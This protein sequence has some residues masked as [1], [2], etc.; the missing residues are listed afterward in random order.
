MKDF[1]LQT[2]EK[3]LNGYLSLDP[4]SVKRLL[5]LDKKIISLH[6][7]MTHFQIKI[8]SGRIY[9]QDAIEEPHVL[10]RGTPFSFLHAALLKENRKSFF[11]DHII[12][13]GD[14][15]LG[16]QIIDLF[17]ELEIDWEE[18]LSKVTGDVAAHQIGNVAR[19]THDFLKRAQQSFLKQTSEYVHEEA[20]LFP[21]R[22]ALEDFF[23]EID[24]LRMHADRLEQQVARLKEETV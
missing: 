23:Q 21:P 10:I 22:E 15:E 20:L 9:L 6:A 12:I 2:A 14:L 18:Y 11:T 17:D 5:A 19:K 7:G 1:L 3:L 13:E 8:L 24:E 4:E 16:Q